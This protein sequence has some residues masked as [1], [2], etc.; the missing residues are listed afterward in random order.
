MGILIAVAHAVG[1]VV[2]F[3]WMRRAAKHRRAME[4]KLERWN[5]GWQEQRRWLAEFPDVVGALENLRCRADGL[6]YTDIELVRKILRERRD[7]H[8]LPPEIMPLYVAT[9]VSTGAWPTLHETGPV[10]AKAAA[11]SESEFRVAGAPSTES[12]E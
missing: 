10:T 2:A 11:A 5:T 9:Y 6:E 4:D 8:M 3:S 1:L 12:P 7:K